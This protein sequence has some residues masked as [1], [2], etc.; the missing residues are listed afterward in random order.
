MRATWYDNTG[1]A[2]EV[3]TYGELPAPG[4][5]RVRIHA[6]GADPGDANRHRGWTNPRTDFPE[7]V[8]HDGGAGVIDAAGPG[9]DLARIATRV[10]LRDA[11]AGRPIGTAAAYVRLLDRNTE[12]LPGP[13]GSAQGAWISVPGP[14]P[15][16]RLWRDGSF[17][18]A[19]VLVAGAAGVVGNAAVG[20]AVAAGAAAIGTVGREQR[21]RRPMRRHERDRRGIRDR[22]RARARR[23]GVV[24]AECQRDSARRTA[25]PP[26]SRRAPPGRRRPRPVALRRGRV[27]ARRAPLRCQ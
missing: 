17:T 24:L 21:N 8:P 3:F 20:P 5:G 2:A 7:R 1:P 18:G 9:V 4:G 22:R 12:P 10:R 26:A 19:M 11:R 13:I 23:T 6:S 14:T 27:Q 15:H 25:A 16:R